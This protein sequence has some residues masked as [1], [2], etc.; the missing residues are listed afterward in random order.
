MFIIKFNPSFFQRNFMDV[1]EFMEYFPSTES[2]NLRQNEFYKKVEIGLK[3]GEYV[4]VKGNIS[5]VFI[6]LYK[7]LSQ[8]DTDGFETLSEFLI[9]V[10]EL[11]KHEEK[12]SNSALSW[13][14]DCLL[15]LEKYEE[16]L[17]KTEPVNLT[18]TRTH[19]SNLR[20]NVQRKLGLSANPI[21]I[22]LM[23][24]G[25]K[26]KFIIN[27]QA[28]YKENVI[29]CFNKYG[30]ESGGWFSIF[31]SL[32]P[33]GE[34]YQHSLF[35]GAPLWDKPSLCWK[36]K[37]FYSANGLQDSVKTLAS[38]AENAAREIIG[39][40]R[41]GEGWV[42]ETELYR[43]L[44]VEF[45]S[46]KVVQHGRPFWLGQQHFDIWFPNW[47]IAVEYHGKQHFEPVDFFG[48]E[49]AFEKTVA[50][51]RR[52]I[53]LAK[54]HGVLLY[55]VTEESDQEELINNIYALISNRKIFPPNS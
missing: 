27:N 35:S 39:V 30:E 44:E 49:E 26:T 41:I 33:N 40:P 45:S 42:S 1:P 16:Y 8:W 13:A 47:K 32:L 34:L 24:G 12:I 17:D 7:L 28:L 38:N 15:G 46:T 54:R 52:K 50:R 18:K 10:S 29:E 36:I 23:V 9:Y 4:D 14:Y 2:M 11:Y 37:A 53:N 43:K 3:R 5:Y 19:A 48:G 51:D 25:R 22:L 6:Y 55:V 20:I 21:D 31:D